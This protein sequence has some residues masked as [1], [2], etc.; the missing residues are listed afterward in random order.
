MSLTEQ[1]DPAEIRAFYEAQGRQALTSGGA[2]RCSEATVTQAVIDLIR[3]YV[4]SL[5]RVLDVG[6]GSNLEYDLVLAEQGVSV[7]GVD[8]STSFLELAPKHPRIEL[9][10]ANATALPFQAGEFDA[11]ICSE[12]AEHVPDDRAVVAE[13]ARVLR[14]RGLLVFTVPIL[15]NLARLREM[16]ARRSREVRMMEGHLR[17]YTR[18]QALTLLRPM[19]EV[20]RI[21]PVP[22]GWRGPLGTPL[23]LLVRTGVLSRASKS[24]A[25]LARRR[26]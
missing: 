3:P 25:A 16:L 8:F 5:G 11:A 14:P 7:V 12:T 18:A 22:F 4:S 19:F 23:D 24:F 21:L 10:W 6:C 26:H 20:E 2:I 13:I 9:R 15:W 1:S 17:E